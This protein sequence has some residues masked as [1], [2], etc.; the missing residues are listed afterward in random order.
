M[1]GLSEL[2]GLMDLVKEVEFPE[3]DWDQMVGDLLSEGVG[4]IVINGGG[5]PTLT[6]ESPGAE[7][8]GKSGRELLDW[9]TRRV[10]DYYA[11]RIEHKP[12][13]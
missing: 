1:S 8:E 3:G 5:D 2:I 12:E 13:D 11:H 9:A 7:D 4:E 6:G 10:G